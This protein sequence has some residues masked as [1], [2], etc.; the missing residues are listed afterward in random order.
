MATPVPAGRPP[1]QLLRGKRW[2]LC[3]PPHLVRHLKQPRLPHLPERPGTPPKAPRYT[4][5]RVRVDVAIA[6]EERAGTAGSPTSRNNGETIR[7]RLH[8]TTPR[9]RMEVKPLAM[10]TT[11]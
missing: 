10:L 7:T 3:L 2:R 5:I 8:I 4:T 1:T 11:C 6:L 9:P